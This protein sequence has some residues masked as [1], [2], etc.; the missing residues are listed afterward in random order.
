MG[1]RASLHRACEYGDLAEVRRLLTTATDEC[2]LEATDD[3]GRTPLLLAVAR[4]VPLRSHE[5]ETTTTRETDDDDDDGVNSDVVRTDR[6]HADWSISEQASQSAG[7]LFPSYD[8]GTLARDPRAL[9]GLAPEVAILHL[10]LR[11]GANVAHSDENGRTALH[12]ACLVQNAVAIRMLLRAGARPTRERCGLLPQDLLQRGHMSEWAAQAQAL[13]EALEQVTNASGYAMTL[14]AFRPSGIVQLDMGGQVEKGSFVTLEYDVPE[15]H[16]VKDYVQVLVSE[17]ASMEIQMGSYHYVPAGGHGQLTIST[18]EIPA[19]SIVRFV[20][21][22]CDINTMSREVVA[23]GCNAVVQASV[24]EIFQ[25]ELFLYDRVVEVESIAK[26]EFIDQPLIV[27]K[28]IGILVGEGI[29]WVDV[30]PDNHI[31]AVNDVRID[32]MEFADAVRILQVNNG[33]RCTKLLMQNYSACGDFIPEKILGVGVVEKYAYLRPVDEEHA[34]EGQEPTHEAWM[35]GRRGSCHEDGSEDVASSRDAGP[36]RLGTFSSAV[37]L[38]QETT[39]TSVP[40]SVS[41]L[42]L[43]EEASV[44]TCE[45]TAGGHDYRPA[46][47]NEQTSCAVSTIETVVPLQNSL[48]LL[49]QLQHGISIGQAAR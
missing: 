15:T 27:L 33:R 40:S 17:A 24:G 23:S 32:A 5:E 35:H 46:T 39:G 45:A 22:K 29:D 19:A 34:S 10:L 4:G 9:P 8:H 13:K 30:R 41:S 12:Y 14:L 26:F 47:D 3:C 20:Y 11:H 44:A 49:A 7:V 31:V 16:S 2:D 37:Q 18:K 28:R 1:N 21:V 25:Y 42:L 36:S 38:P 48:E 6:E 43:Q